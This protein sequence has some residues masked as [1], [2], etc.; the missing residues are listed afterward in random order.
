[1]PADDADFRAF[2]EQRWGQLNRTAY[3]LTGDRGIAE[4]LVQAA[5][6]KAHRHWARILRKDA[7]EVYV[8]R[9]MV[10]TALSW[11]RRRRVAEVPLLAGDE[12]RGATD[13][14]YGRADTRY[15]VLAALR[16]LPPR[17]RAVLVLRYFEDLSEAEIARALRCSPG[18]VKS[19]ASRGLARLRAELTA[20]ESTPLPAAGGHIQGE[21]A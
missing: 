9:V 20:P 2:V 19:Q 10:N 4:D 11:R 15:E 21:P 7:P 14:P 1:M 6:E 13:D 16:R 12:S 5:L 8:R 3:L 18:S 17:T